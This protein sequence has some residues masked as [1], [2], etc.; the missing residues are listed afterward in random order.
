MLLSTQ[1]QESAAHGPCPAAGG[2]TR[3]PRALVSSAVPPLLLRCS[4]LLLRC[5]RAQRPTLL[6]RCCRAPTPNAPPALL[7]CP[8]A[9]TA[10]QT[11]CCRP[12]CARRRSRRRSKSSGRAR[13]RTRR[14]C[15]PRADWGC[16]QLCPPVVHPRVLAFCLPCLP[17]C[18]GVNT[19]APP[20]SP[21]LANAGT[22]GSSRGRALRPRIPR[23]QQA[24]CQGRAPGARPACACW[25][26]CAR[27]PACQQHPLGTADTVPLQQYTPQH[28]HRSRRRRS[29]RS[30]A[31]SASTASGAAAS[32]TPS[33]STSDQRQLQQAGGATRGAVLGF[34]MC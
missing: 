6:L 4:P 30:R 33:P 22:P 9:P 26:W 27:G 3:S 21:T 11:S 24:L 1:A 7:P 28:H 34:L 18:R 2:H 20:P 23:R 8:N 25:G 29:T 10:A 13:R 12:S 32:A 19:L 16:K 14:R 5:C 31:L 15:M 17:V